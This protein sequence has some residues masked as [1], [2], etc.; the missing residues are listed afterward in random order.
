MKTI[1]TLTA[2][3]MLLGGVSIADAQNQKTS[4]VT[5]SPNAINEGSRT[6][7]PSGSQPQST[8]QPGGTTGQAS[9]DLVRGSGAFCLQQQGSS[10]DCK[11]A[12][13]QNC[14]EEAKLQVGKTCVPN[15]RQ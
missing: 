9:P 2:V 4:P 11:F 7:K 1:T 5:S 14:E 3:A 15:P 6:Y 10:L 8:A 13:K 12:T